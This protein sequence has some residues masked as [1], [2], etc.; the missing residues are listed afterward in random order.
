MG[1]FR[2][3]VGGIRWPQGQQVPY[4]RYGLHGDLMASPLHG[5]FYEATKQGNVYT[6][7]AA[8]AGVTLPIYSNTAQVFGLWN[9]STDVDLELIELTLNHVG[10]PSVS[11]NLGFGVINAGQAIAT[12]NISA[13]TKNN[14]F[15]MSTLTIQEAP[16][17]KSCSALTVVAIGATQFIPIGLSQ[18][19]VLAAASTTT[20]WTVLMKQFRGDLIVPPGMCIVL[21]GNVAQ[22]QPFGVTLSWAEWA[23]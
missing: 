5:S 20:P 15:K 22:T 8:V 6:V 21:C 9:Q 2:G 14:P 16:A 13:I 11:G 4:N 19:G 7:A 17:G 18:A 1:A 3:I 12:G 23:R 10:T